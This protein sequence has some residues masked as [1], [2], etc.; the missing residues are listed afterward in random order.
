[1]GSMVRAPFKACLDPH[2]YVIFLVSLSPESMLRQ[3]VGTAAASF[4]LGGCG[5]LLY[6]SIR[7]HPSASKSHDTGSKV[8]GRAFSCIEW[9]GRVPSLLVTG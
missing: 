2:L 4:K 8:E 5:L 9:G 7:C 1:M 6:L 3:L